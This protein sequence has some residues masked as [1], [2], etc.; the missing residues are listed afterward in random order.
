MFLFIV[1]DCRTEFKLDLVEKHTLRSE[2]ESVTARSGSEIQPAAFAETESPLLCSV[3]S[4]RQVPLP[5]PFRDCFLLSHLGGAGPRPLLLGQRGLFKQVCHKKARCDYD[6]ALGGWPEAT[7]HFDKHQPLKE[8][9]DESQSKL[10]ILG[11][12]S[13]RSRKGL[14]QE[15]CSAPP[16]TYSL[17]SGEQRGG[18]F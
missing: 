16:P 4:G 10:C 2:K 18:S 1:P 7:A 11:H 13:H 8:Q 15:D 12:A 5:G 3:P 17:D 14:P 9:R 6:G